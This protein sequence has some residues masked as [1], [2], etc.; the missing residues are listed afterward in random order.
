[1]HSSIPSLWAVALTVGLSLGVPAALEGQRARERPASPAPQRPGRFFG[2]VVDATTQRP[3]AGARIASPSI[4]GVVVTDSAGKFDIAEV[5]PGLVRFHIVAPGYPRATVVLP[6]GSGEVMERVLEL[7][8][9][10][11]VAPEAPVPIAAVTVEAAPLPPV[12]M[13][14]FERRRTTG[15][16]QYVTREQIEQRNYNRLSDVLQVMRGVTLDCGGGGSGC[17]IRMARASLQCLPAYWVDGVLNNTWGPYVPV[18]D[19]EGLEVYTGAS[20]TPGEFAGSNSACGTIV[21][22]TSSGP[23]RPN[24]R[25]P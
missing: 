12:W 8:S 11:A 3:V 20:D 22:W 5:P 15:R 24:N 19:I 4:T 7:D 21:I 25:N 10:T 16:G 23:R 1:M 18:R 9:T 14:D 6:F 17:T 2:S 13:R